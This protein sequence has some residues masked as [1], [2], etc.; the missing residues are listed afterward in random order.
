MGLIE[1]AIIAMFGSAVLGI[2]STGA[3]NKA[4][5]TYEETAIFEA[6]EVSRDDSEYPQELVNEI[7]NL[8]ENT[9]SDIIETS[10]GYTIV[11]VEE[12]IAPT[13]DKINEINENKEAT[14]EQITQTYI[15][16][17]KTQFFFGLIDEWKEAYDIQI[18][19]EVWQD[20]SIN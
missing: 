7:F 12:F 8:K 1:L 11:L 9:N 17:Q 4:S 16:Q 6:V 2:A 20:I 18:N 14:L 15:N 5:K 13:E 10:V 19:E 3:K